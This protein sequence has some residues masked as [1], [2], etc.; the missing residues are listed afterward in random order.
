[1]L[2]GAFGI[3]QHGTGRCPDFLNRSTD[4]CCRTLD[5][6][7][8]L[9][10]K[11]LHDPAFFLGRLGFVL[12]AFALGFLQTFGILAEHF[13]RPCHAA[14]FIGPP[15]KGHIDIRPTIGKFAHH[16][17]Q[18]FDRH[19]D[20]ARDGKTDQ[21]H[22]KDGDNRCND[23][24]I[25]GCHAG[26]HR[27]RTGNIHA[28]F[29]RFTKLGQGCHQAFVIRLCRPRKTQRPGMLDIKHPQ[30]L[31][32]LGKVTFVKLGRAFRDF[33]FR[34][35]HV[36][37]TQHLGKGIAGRRNLRLQFRIHAAHTVFVNTCR[38]P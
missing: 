2:I 16:R 27:I 37:I 11:F 28:A 13:N 38:R 29:R 33:A 21:H 25:L 35:L 5:R 26:C 34:P 32:D 10:G 17:R 36:P 1:M 19:P 9:G 4:R 24:L 23:C 31:V 18:P 30:N 14:H 3:G 12:Y 20:H 22:R 15:G 8:D 6:C 7:F